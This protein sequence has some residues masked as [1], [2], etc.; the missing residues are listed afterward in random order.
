MRKEG[1]LDEEEE[2][3][4]MNTALVAQGKAKVEIAEEATI[5]SQRSG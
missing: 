5:T 4:L 2:E 1:P 3:F